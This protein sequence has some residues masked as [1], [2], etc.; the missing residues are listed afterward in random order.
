MTQAANTYVPDD[1][2]PR[3]T[4]YQLTGDSALG[5]TLLVSA[6]RRCFCVLSSLATVID[7]VSLECV[8]YGCYGSAPSGLPGLGDPD[9]T[10][11]VTEVLSDDESVDSLNEDSTKRA[12]VFDRL[13]TDD[14]L[15]L[16][17]S[18]MTF[19]KAVGNEES[20]GLS[21]FPLA[22]KIQSCVHI[23]KELATEAMKTHR[24]TLYG[25]FLGP[26]L[27]FPVVERYVKAVW[28]K[29]GF[30]DV[31]MNNNGIFFFKFNDVGGS[32]QVVEA[33]PLM[34]R[35]VPLFVEHWDPVKGLT[36]PIHNSCPLWVKLHNVP[37]VAFNKE[38]ISR[39]ASVLGIPKQMDAC[40]ASM[41]DKAWGRPGFAKVL[42]ETWA[43]GELKREIQV[44]IPSLIGGEDTRVLI[45]VEYLWEPSQCS[46]CLV[47]GH[48][49]AT[50]VKA[51]V[52]Q[53]NKGKATVVDDD[54][55]TRVQRKEWRP[56]IVGSTSGTKEDTPLL[57]VELNTNVASSPIAETPTT[58]LV[59]PGL[60]SSPGGSPNLK[61]KEVQQ[62]VQH[63]VEKQGEKPSKES[64]VEDSIKAKSVVTHLTVPLDVPIKSILKNTN[65]FS[66]LAE[67]ETRKNDD[68]KLKMKHSVVKPS[69][70]LLQK[71]RGDGS[72]KGGSQSTSRSTPGI[73][74]GVCDRV[75]RRWSWVSN[76]S[77]CSSGTR[78]IVAWDSSMVDVM[79]LETHSQFIHCDVR[80]RDSLDQFFVSIVYGANRGNERQCLWSG[81]RK[82]RVLMGAK[83]WLVAGDFNCLLFPHDALD[84]MSRRNADMMAFASCVEDV[85]LFDI[86]FGGIHHT[87]CQ[88]PKE[89]AGLRRKLD[90]IL[91]NTEF[92]S[93]F[94]DV[95]VRFLPR[96]LSDHSPGLAS[97]KGD[98]RK[99]NF[100]FK[101]DNF[102]AHDP[103]FLDIV[104][105]GWESS[106]EG[107]F[108]FRLL[109]K[110]K[111]LKTP[112]RR[113]R[114]SH[115]NLSEKTILLKHE[116]DTAQLSMDL[117][118]DNDLLRE[119]LQHIRIAYQHS[120]WNDMSAARQRAKVN[121]LSDGDSNSKFFHQV[122]K[123]RRNSRHIYSVCNSDG[124]FV[125]DQQV[126]EAFIDHFKVIIGSTDPN[127]VPMMPQTMFATQL[128]LTDANHMIRPIQDME[129][130]DAIF[131]IGND[132]A[133]GSDGFS[134]KFFK[135][136]WEV[137]GPDVL[138]AI[139]N[140]FYRGR[141][142]K[143]LNHTLLC[144]LPKTVNAT[145]VTDF[146]PIACCS[147][148]YK[149][150]AKVIVERIKPYLSSLVSKSQS[151]FIPGRRIGDNILM[152]HELV[153]GYHLHK[154]PPRCAFKIDLRKAYDMVSWEYLFQMLNG[155][156]FH[157][158]MI[159]WIRE[160]VTSPS[161]SIVLNGETY[162]HFLGKRGIR[163]GDPL[164]PY[165][166]TLIMEGFTMIMN[167]CIM[168]AAEFGYHHGCADLGI[169][170]LCFA[171]DLFVFSRGDVASVG[172][173][174]KALELFAVRSGLSP[175]L[176]K[177][178]V[179]F[180]NVADQE[181]LAILNCL[182]FRQG[183][184]PIRYLGVPLSP[185]ALKAA[186]YG[187]MIARV[188][189]RI[190]NWKSKFLSFAGR[191]QLIIS[192]LQSL[193]LYW[194]AVYV[195][196]SV[197]THQL[198]ALFRDFLWAQG[199]SSKGKCKVAWSLVCRPR[200]CGGLGIKRLGVWNRAIVAKNLWA[201]M[202]KQNTLWVRWIYAHVLRD[203][204]FWFA[205]KNGRWSWM[206]SKMMA[207]RSELRPFVSVR[208]GDGRL[209]NAWEDRWLPCGPLVHLI[210]Y[211]VYHA[212]SLSV[213]ST[214][215]QLLQV[216][217][218]WPPSWVERCPQLAMF[219]LPVINQND[220][221]VFCWDADGGKEE[222]SVQR[223]YCS[224]RGP[225]PTI[226]WAKRVWFKGHIPKH[227]FCLWLVC[228]CRLPTQ[229]R[230]ADWKHDPPDYKCSLCKVCRDSH[231]HLFFE[232]DYA[233]DVWDMVK[234]KM[235][236][237]DAPSTWE[238]LVT[239]LSGPAIGHGSMP[240]LLALSAAVYMI[241][242]E[243]N[244]RLFTEE[245][246]PGIK[247]MK[248]ILEIVENRL[249]WKKRKRR[250]LITD[251]ETQATG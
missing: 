230:L 241:W 162:G 167:Q 89:E 94:Q 51:L 112:L 32:N 229:D 7:C 78:I 5:L 121:W 36:K 83:P 173:L 54:G 129:I 33:G 176:Q 133:P 139:H 240:Y 118:P 127:V 192:V 158:V 8:T 31:M 82:F 21:F 246:T 208:V 125:Y 122:V 235:R 106:V 11:V 23:P 95:S 113:L 217:Q 251:V 144:L 49:S 29:Y 96:G 67:G 37:L 93:L 174:K 191:R 72:A 138:L 1:A 45:K 207:L 108:M 134:A 154:G 155:F 161:F 103:K 123:E 16:N 107:T 215:N 186:D 190:G 86:R 102:L 165:L 203:A 25:Y 19:A 55:F 219:D 91:A 126:A 14:R 41:C 221:D 169:T 34:I 59:Q 130:K 116:L 76:H 9:P 218:N 238:A 178:D 120:C 220:M 194:M 152:A 38:G 52:A 10:M 56:K 160:M 135:A 6:L 199:D 74:G 4:T 39:I 3:H 179:F 185:V 156:G 249:A 232:C 242:A 137:I 175:N 197:V 48:K 80:F 239:Y 90:R 142:A 66:P 200:E 97:F 198:E 188:N 244:R 110:L 181:K 60:E 222:F 100:S 177:S 245:K 146:R 73:L 243:R 171:D 226:P 204:N 189:D 99:R 15:K 184:F 223:A 193:Q 148:L 64:R 227:S 216:M 231:A 35:G 42:V 145:A 13:E 46:H 237:N 40:T 104:K 166:F 147:I 47:F 27:Q 140:F 77:H 132:K 2:S 57:N 195:F 213:S 28:G 30:C 62:E 136:A 172:V 196:P 20:T 224:F 248:N 210:P 84:G 88:K 79:V 149:C 101:F 157:P 98:L 225:L 115:G 214:V 50:C 124:V 234:T 111:R 228:L 119:D 61:A 206:F 87:W 247:L 58:E 183:S 17:A 22:S 202:T 75:F 187:C 150:I 63:S 212:V 81:L 163:Q 70:D 109:S 117:D 43:V 164:S 18:D 12:S 201:V 85:E 209:L 69:V 105:R 92:T 170:H 159:K 141:L 114:S 68:G 153:L 168:E 250:T 128:S 71:P 236:W 131:Q 233:K 211:R 205:R 180:G 26:R 151:A 24:S 53:K 44:V 65:R 143:E 182:P